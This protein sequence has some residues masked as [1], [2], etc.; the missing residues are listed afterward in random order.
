MLSWSKP[1][2]KHSRLESCWRGLDHC[3]C[4]MG[5]G[6]DFEWISCVCLCPLRY[7]TPPNMTCTWDLPQVIKTHLIHSIQTAVWLY[8]CKIHTVSIVVETEA[9]FPTV[10]PE[11]VSNLQ[12]FH[13]FTQQKR[14]FSGHIGP[15]NLSWMR[16]RYVN[17]IVFA[18]YLNSDHCL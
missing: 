17:W 14:K 9:P 12:P 2:K 15:L 8:L 5:E 4:W 6:G 13:E 1:K 11:L 7:D 18:I 3:E 10:G 16:N